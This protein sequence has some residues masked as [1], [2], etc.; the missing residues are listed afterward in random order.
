[1]RIDAY[2]RPRKTDRVAI[3]TPVREMSEPEIAWLAGIYDGEGSLSYSKHSNA[4]V[5]SVNMT[6]Q[7]VIDHLAQVT[8]VGVVA[9][10]KLYPNRKQQ[11]Q[12][13]VNMRVQQAVLLRAMHPWLS[14]RRRARIAEFETWLETA[15]PGRS[16]RRAPCKRGHDVT[17]KT[18]R[19]DCRPCSQIRAR[20]Q[21]KRTA[22]TRRKLSLVWDTVT[23]VSRRYERAPD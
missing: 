8:G 2:G 5:L 17:D 11:W 6:D 15:G 20:E 12:W 18:K 4:W 22:R 23:V 21:A 3:Y 13:R 10:R 7:D 9:P 14:A 1:M 19:G 16:E